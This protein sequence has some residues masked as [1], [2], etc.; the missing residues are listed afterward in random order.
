MKVFPLLAV[1]MLLMSGPAL[2]NPIERA[3]NASDRSAATRTMCA[4]IG[5]AA[6]STLSRGDMRTGA[7]FFDDP[8]RAQ[9]VRT[10]DRASDERFWDR[11]RSFGEVAQRMCS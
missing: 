5:A 4:C 8:Q 1:A 2:A 6:D 11:W 9:A 3:C 10:S 7:R